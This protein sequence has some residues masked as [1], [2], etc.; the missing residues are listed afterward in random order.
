MLYPYAALRDARFRSCSALRCQPRARSKA[1]SPRCASGIHPSNT[2]P[3]GLPA[4]LFS[5]CV[6]ARLVC[7]CGQ[8]P[9]P[10]QR[11]PGRLRSWPPAQA[12]PPPLRDQPQGAFLPAKI[13]LLKGALFMNYLRVVWTKQT[14]PRPGSCFLGMLVRSHPAGS[15]AVHLH[16]RRCVTCKARSARD[17]NQKPQLGV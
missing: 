6:F 14:F 9:W 5:P 4:V 17:R 10:G 11:L 8:Q 2:A 7:A 15:L 12:M 1:R 16:L 3:R 13:Q